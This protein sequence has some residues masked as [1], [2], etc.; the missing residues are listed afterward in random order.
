MLFS[1]LPRDRWDTVLL[2]ENHHSS[3]ADAKE[4][5]RRGRR[6][7][8]CHGSLPLEP[9]HPSF[10]GRGVLVSQSAASRLSDIQL[11]HTCSEEC[12]LGVDSIHEGKCIP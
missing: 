12:S 9:R 8:P 1:L 10:Q 2:Q 5:V 7:T 11:Q 4:G 3:Q 6:L